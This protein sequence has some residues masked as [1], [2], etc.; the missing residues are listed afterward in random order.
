M[1]SSFSILLIDD[2]DV[3]IEAAKRNLAKHHVNFPIFT[4]TNGKAGLAA[5]RGQGPD[6]PLPK[7]LVVL[8]DLNMP[9][10][11]GFEFLQ[12]LRT[13]PELKSRVVFALTTSDSEIDRMR[14]YESQIAG[15]MVKSSLGPQFANLAR[16]LLN[17]ETSVT[18]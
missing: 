16:L 18:F 13:D 8:L 9:I 2:D 7:Q 15:Y 10:M 1:N 11:D 14:A 3:A 5:L 6:G 12:V 17:Y 4:A